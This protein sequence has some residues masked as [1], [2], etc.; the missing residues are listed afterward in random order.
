M[1]VKGSRRRAAVSFAVVSLLA[2][3]CGSAAAPS[4]AAKPSVVRMT[5][6]Q[7]TDPM[8]DHILAT[9]PSLQK[10]VPA[11]IKFLPVNTG[12]GALAGYK[13]GSYDFVDS[14]GNPP[15][16]GAIA[17][18]LPFHVI[19]PETEDGAVIVVKSSIQSPTQLAGKKI[20][21]LVGSS[22]DFEL[23]GYLKTLGLE[24]K[25][26]I[27]ELGNMASN[28]PTFKTGQEDAGYVN[29]SIAEEMMKD[30]GVPL[31]ADDGSVVTA[32]YIGTRGYQSFNSAT[33]A[34]SFA[35]KYPDVVQRF[36]CALYEATKVERG[37]SDQAE[38]AFKRA[39]A[40]AGIADPSVA[41]DGGKHTPTVDPNR[42]PD[43]LSPASSGKPDTGAVAKSLYLTSQFLVANGKLTSPLSQDQIQSY[44]DPTWARNAVAG[45]CPKPS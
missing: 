36:V 35:K 4:G 20:G 8:Q 24:G 19:W 3:A 5:Y 1:H 7:N 41:V 16:T 9:T 14:V 29:W 12:P 22:E 15:V 10:L 18:K 11:P 38:A 45:K 40:Y 25:V 31:K 21:T 23:R 30:G 34:D 6:F 28:V 44:L 32:D 26:T 2:I 27:V 43:F 39:G 42:I 13:A 17:A 37:P 33:V